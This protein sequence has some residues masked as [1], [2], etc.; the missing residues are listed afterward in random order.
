L[1]I[2]RGEVVVWIARDERYSPRVVLEFLSSV[3]YISSCLC[4]TEE[5]YT[6]KATKWGKRCIKSKIFR[7]VSIANV[8]LQKVEASASAGLSDE[9][10]SL[11]VR[12]N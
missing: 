8:L 11:S 4:S 12:K 2:A 6:R 9:A 10:F 3:P 7:F 5:R 1:F